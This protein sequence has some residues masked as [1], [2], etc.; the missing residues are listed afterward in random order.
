MGKKQGDGS[1]RMRMGMGAIFLTIYFKN[2]GFLVF[3]DIQFFT[4]AWKGGEESDYLFHC[5][6]QTTYFL[7][8]R[9]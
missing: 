3:Y 1:M 5:L 9:V 7:R 8:M 4:F 2:K 6:L